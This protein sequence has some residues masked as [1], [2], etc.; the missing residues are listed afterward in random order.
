MCLRL[1]LISCV[2]APQLPSHIATVQLLCHFQAV[3]YALIFLPL[4]D[5]CVGD[6][7]WCYIMPIHAAAAPKATIPHPTP[8]MAA[9]VGPAF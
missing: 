5:E 4:R 3:F 1:V 8:F 7:V 2:F 9:S 6:L